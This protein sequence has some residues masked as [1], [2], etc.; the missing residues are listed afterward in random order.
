MKGDCYSEQKRQ[1]SFVFT[2][3][4]FLKGIFIKDKFFNYLIR[5]FSNFQVLTQTCCCTLFDHRLN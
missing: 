4:P 1:V 2:D 5:N 3:L